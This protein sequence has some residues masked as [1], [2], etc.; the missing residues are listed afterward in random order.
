[1]LSILDF[2]NP[3]QVTMVLAGEEP[4]PGL[5]KLAVSVLHGENEEDPVEDSG[6]ENSV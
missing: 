4:G 6:A 5:V 2:G 3:A 1:M